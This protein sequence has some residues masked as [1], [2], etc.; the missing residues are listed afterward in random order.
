[1]A[2]TSGENCCSVAIDVVGSFGSA[3]SN[4][5]LTCVVVGAES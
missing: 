4:G 3:C 5:G 2:K 1:M